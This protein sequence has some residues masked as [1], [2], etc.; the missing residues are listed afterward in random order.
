MVRTGKKKRADRTEYARYERVAKSLLSS[1]SAL[2]ELAS[3][4]DSYGNAAA[5]IAIHA[6]IAYNDA[7]TIAYREVKSAEGDHARAVD[8]L[9]EAL[10]S[11]L[12]PK[13]ESRLRAVLKKKDAVSYGGSY[14]SVEEARHLLERV[15]EFA[16]WAE[17]TLQRRPA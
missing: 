8:V 5:I 12:P 10:G 4:G 14:Y 9:R 6:A 3:E 7:V 1:A 2:V 17:E 11:D 15:R 16:A 13:V